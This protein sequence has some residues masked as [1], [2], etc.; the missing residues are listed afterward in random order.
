MQT[1]KFNENKNKWIPFEFGLC[2]I[3]KSKRR[4]SKCCSQLNGVSSRDNKFQNRTNKIYQNKM[5]T[6]LVNRA[7]GEIEGIVFQADGRGQPVSRIML[8]QCLV[9]INS[10]FF[11]VM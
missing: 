3:E 5:V 7:R 9:S 11:L 4:I 6:Q 2:Y 1:V 8:K 10:W